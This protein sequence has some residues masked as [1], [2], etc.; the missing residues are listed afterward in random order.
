MS[1]QLMSSSAFTGGNAF[2]ITDFY[3][4]LLGK[5]DLKVAFLCGNNDKKWFE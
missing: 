2:L 4:E 1:T 5:K 3:K